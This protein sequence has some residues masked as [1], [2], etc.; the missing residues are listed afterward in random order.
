M[1]AVS[2][3]PEPKSAAR[4]GR[5]TVA[6]ALEVIDRAFP[7]AANITVHQLCHASHPTVW[8]ELDHDYPVAQLP[9]LYDANYRAVQLRLL[10]RNRVVRYP[11]YE[12]AEFAEEF[13]WQPGDRLLVYANQG[14]RP[15]VI[16]AVAG[17]RALAEY[18]MPGGSTALRVVDRDDPNAGR[19]RQLGDG[20]SY[21]CCP[22]LWLAA[23][24]WAGT[25]WVG[26]PQQASRAA[27]S[28]ASLLAAAGFVVGVPNGSEFTLARRKA[29]ATRAAAAAFA[30]HI[31]GAVILPFAAETPAE[32]PAADGVSAAG[33][34]T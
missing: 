30:V 9:R 29:F 21:H 22:L 1:P 14:D 13:S 10:D 16:L 24:E 34:A 11:D 32:T 25:A 23:I 5:V 33:T 20:I 2:P 28:A 3:Q 15:A 17:G 26:E 12:L 6:R 31:A 27:P 18:E 4:R 8:R 7:G 19:G